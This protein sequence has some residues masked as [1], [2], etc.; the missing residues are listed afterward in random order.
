MKLVGYFA[1][2]VSVFEVPL[3]CLCSLAI[4]WTFSLQ[5]AFFSYLR[6][7]FWWMQPSLE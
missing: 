3:Q 5:C 2:L 7:C 4:R 1:W 6:G